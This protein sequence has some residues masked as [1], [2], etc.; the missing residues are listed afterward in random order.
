MI[1]FKVLPQFHNI[2]HLIAKEPA[3]WCPA[4]LLS[5]EHSLTGFLTGKVYTFLEKR[6]PKNPTCS[7]P[8]GKASDGLPNLTKG[9]PVSNFLRIP[10]RRGAGPVLQSFRIH[11]PA[12]RKRK[13]RA[14][15]RNQTALGSPFQVQGIT[16]QCWLDA[17]Q[18]QAD[19][20]KACSSMS[21]QFIQFT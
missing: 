17:W 9:S 20:Y 12:I 7:V 16:N 4:G 5:L 11:L 8:E 15:S 18:S 21:S 13:A 10:G 6:L 1:T 3:S 2:L 14:L 19:G